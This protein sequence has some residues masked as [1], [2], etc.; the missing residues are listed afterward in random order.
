MSSSSGSRRRGRRRDPE[1]AMAQL[2]AADFLQ[3][4]AGGSGPAGN[5]KLDA[6]AAALG[7]GDNPSMDERRP[8]PREGSYLAALRATAAAD[9]NGAYAAW[10]GAV[11]ANPTDRFA[12]E[13]VVTATM[14]YP[15]ELGTSYT[16]PITTHGPCAQACQIWF[17]RGCVWAAAYHRRRPSS[18]LGR[19]PRP[20]RHAPW[21][22]GA[23]RCATGRTTTS[24]QRGVLCRGVTA[25]W[26]PVPQGGQRRDRQGPRA[27]HS[28]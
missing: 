12:A 15:I 10:L 19:P 22:T 13:R 17:D 5:E 9:F 6:A 26:L 25:E 8:A 27:H 24:R 18:A 23:W 20:T 28:R 3:Q 1:S 2:L 16:Q 21:R 11:R 14:G 7:G 4:S